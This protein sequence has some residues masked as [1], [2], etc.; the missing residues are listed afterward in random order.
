[1]SYRNK[2]YVIFDGDNDRWAYAYMKGWKENENVDFNFY[3][4]HD[5]KPLTDRASEQ[6]IRQRLRE[7]LSSAK[8]VI[9]LVGESTKDL[10]VFV[11]WEIDIALKMDL[12]GF[13]GKAGTFPKS[14]RSAFRN[15]AGHDSGMKPGT[16]S[17]F[18]PVTFG[19]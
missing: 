8:Q 6:T 7:R 3:D 9:V 18:K 5:I 12:C 16:D 13:R 11:R 17:D 14:S 19:R 2:T 4:A 15:E 1:M 10:Y